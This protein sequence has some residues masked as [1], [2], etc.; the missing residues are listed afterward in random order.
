MSLSL[1]E[2]AKMIDHSLLKPQLTREEVREGCCLAA[3]YGTAAVCCRP[4][5]IKLC[6][7]VLKGSGVKTA[8]VI[9]FPHGS[10]TT[11]SKVYEVG[12]AISLGAEELDMVLN[13]GR[14]IS[15]DT[16]YVKKDIQAVT[17][18]A[19]PHGVPVKVIFENCY[20]RD[21]DKISACEICS[22]A[23]ADFV[24]TSTGFGPGGSTLE[25]LR[26]MRSHCPSSVKIK[27]AG[28]IR[29]LDALL[30]AKEAG[31]VRIG[32]TATA[33]MLDEAEERISRGEL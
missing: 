33:A 25:D 18:S 26:L 24:K 10:N 9:G 15:G 21:E 12:D 28:G 29:T 31:A 17:A 13:I 23:G 6:R 14:L 22:I 8:A 11:E 1:K 20:L 27:A 7:E 3:E 16:E 32:A 30:A 4:S 2:I 5:D 19:H